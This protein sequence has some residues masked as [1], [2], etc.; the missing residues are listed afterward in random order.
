MDKEESPNVPFTIFRTR[1]NKG[2]LPEF[3]PLNYSK[4]IDIDAFRA[5]TRIHFG[6]RPMWHGCVS[7]SLCRHET[8]QQAEET[9][10]V[11]R[12]FWQRTK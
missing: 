3:T 2:T 11:M 7:V 5:I 1:F 10:R 12:G 9:D 8:E 4:I 6:I